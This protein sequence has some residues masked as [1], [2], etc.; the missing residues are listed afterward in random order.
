[1]QNLRVRKENKKAAQL[2]ISHG[3]NSPSKDYIGKHT[4]LNSLFIVKVQT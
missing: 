2:P 3:D 4:L 1:M